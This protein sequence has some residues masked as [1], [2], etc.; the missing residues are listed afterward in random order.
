ML[1]SRNGEKEADWPL[2]TPLET[3][4]GGDDVRPA[5]Y[6]ETPPKSRLTVQTLRNVLGYGGLRG[7]GVEGQKR[8]VN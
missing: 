7:G 1:A 2:D 4:L 6:P 5:T 8:A 3:P